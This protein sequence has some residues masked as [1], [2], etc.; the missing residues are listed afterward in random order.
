[1]PFYIMYLLAFLLHL[2]LLEE[3]L[4]SALA[5]IPVNNLHHKHVFSMIV[6]CEPQCI[7]MYVCHTNLKNLS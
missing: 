1:M 6:P 5:Q 7:C 2:S 3:S 4:L